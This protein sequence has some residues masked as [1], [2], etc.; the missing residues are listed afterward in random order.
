MFSVA[1]GNGALLAPIRAFKRDVLNMSKKF[2]LW[3][4]FA[5]F[6][7]SLP[8]FADSG[9]KKALTYDEFR[10]GE[11][12]IKD[13]VD[14]S[15]EKGMLASLVNELLAPGLIP[16]DAF[17]LRHIMDRARMS[18]LSEAW[19]RIVGRSVRYCAWGPN[20]D[21]DI[22]CID[23]YISKLSALDSSYQY[24]SGPYRVEELK[25]AIGSCKA[26]SSEGHYQVY[27]QSCTARALLLTY[28]VLKESDRRD[29]PHRMFYEAKINVDER[30]AQLRTEAI[31]L[32][33]NLSQVRGALKQLSSP[34]SLQHGQ[35][36]TAKAKLIPS[37]NSKQQSSSDDECVGHPF[38]AGSADSSSGIR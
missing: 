7:L 28:F 3:F 10:R 34:A 12:T 27:E 15:F 36:S 37:T 24:R 20:R 30:R 32:Q 38:R 33:E 23:Q 18:H 22:A 29:R 25:T 2:A 21:Y 11:F 8:A 9:G 14:P 1:N 17:G 31:A 19:R 16:S 5:C 6:A 4:S 26:I 13:I 35:Q